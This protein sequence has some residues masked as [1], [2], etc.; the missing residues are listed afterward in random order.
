MR[1]TRAAIANVFV[2]VRTVAVSQIIA[3]DAREREA[4]DHQQARDRGRDDARHQYQDDDGAQAIEAARL[5]TE[6]QDGQAPST[7][8]AHFA[9]YWIATRAMGTSGNCAKR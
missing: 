8:S 4:S 5:G 2:I 7:A 3:L 9:T 6:S 1:G